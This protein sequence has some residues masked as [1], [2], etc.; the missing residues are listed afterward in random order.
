MKYDLT[1]Q[2]VLDAIIAWVEEDSTPVRLNATV[3]EGSQE[4]EVSELCAWPL[5]PLWVNNDTNV[6]PTQCVFDQ[7][8]Y[9]SWM[10]D[11]DAFGIAVY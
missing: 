6:T 1:A 8:S 9:D 4:G 10:Y 5:R 11:F 3:S 2:T 7:A